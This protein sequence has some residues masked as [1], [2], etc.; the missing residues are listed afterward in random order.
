VFGSRFCT[1][2]ERRVL[3]YF[4]FLG[5]RFLTFASNV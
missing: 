4:H 1:T 2:D 5:N 3:Y